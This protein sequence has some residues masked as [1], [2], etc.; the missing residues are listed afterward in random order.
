MKRSLI[1]SFS[2]IVLAFF[3]SSCESKIS[4]NDHIS[5]SPQ[6]PQPGNE[7]TV[8]LDVTGSKLDHVDSVKMIA[9]L[10]SV[11]LDQTID[12]D[13]V[14]REGEWVAKFLTSDSTKGAILKFKSGDLEF[15]GRKGDFLIPMYDDAGNSVAGSQAGLAVA[16]YFW[17][18]SAGL[19]RDAEKAY[20]TFLN[21][22][23][24]NPEIKDR[25]L[26]YYLSTVSRFKPDESDKIIKM[27]LEQLE[28]K[29]NLTETDLINL[30]KWYG[31]IDNKEI[32]A[33]Y[34][35]KVENKFPQS[36]FVQRQKYLTIRKE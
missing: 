3:L 6:E 32:A 35:E 31:K 8:Y 15:A 33:E 1:Y 36:D 29:K 24:T 21:S 16:Y 7:V 10:Y 23:R 13:M 20:Q 14:K 11:D 18:G 30:A 25:Y 22:F 28:T 4:V 26:D 17:G 19:D 27:E 12:L 5:Y 9:Y 2:L 34:T